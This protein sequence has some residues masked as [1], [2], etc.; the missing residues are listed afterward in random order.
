MDTPAGIPDFA[1]LVAIDREHVEE[2]AISFPTWA[3]HK[4]ELVRRPIVFVMDRFRGTG[5]ISLT[6]TM[7]L[8]GTAMQSAW[9]KNPTGCTIN[10]TQPYF[11]TVA[12]RPYASQREKMLAGLVLDGPAFIQKHLPNCRYYLKLDTDC[13]S[14]G[15][16]VWI[17]P[18]WFVDSPAIIAPR[19]GY[20]KPAGMLDELD[21]WA[22]NTPLAAGPPVIRNVVGA[23]AKH[24]RFISYCQFGNVDWTCEMAKLAGD[25]LPVPSQDTFLS[26]CVARGTLAYYRH[27][28]MKN[29][30]WRHVGSNIKR[31][32]AA[33]AEAMAS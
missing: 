33:A 28:D 8:L 29:L 18:E 14:T 10:P 9:F 25:R 27:V 17:S 31:L 32:R 22:L 15:H 4:P 16:P 1:I 20:S 2:F 26:Y 13:I 7:E 12:D 23:V 11:V 19:W 5:D 6:E 21:R 3:R 30:G 24:R